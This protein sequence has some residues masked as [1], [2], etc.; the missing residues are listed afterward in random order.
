MPLEF[1]ADKPA[2]V[3][4]IKDAS[5]AVAGKAL[6]PIMQAVK[7]IADGPNYVTVTGSDYDSFIVAEVL[8]DDKSNLSVIGAGT[9]CCAGAQL[10]KIVESLPP[11]QVVH[12]KVD[13]KGMLAITAGG[14]KFEIATM[15]AEDYPNLPS[16]D[17][18]VIEVS[19]VVFAQAIDSVVDYADSSKAGVLSGCNLVFDGGHVKSAATDTNIVAAY[20][21]AAGVT[22]KATALIP[23]VMAKK[24]ASIINGQ[25]E[26]D[27]QICVSDSFVFIKSTYRK[28]ITRLIAGVYPQYEQV[29][30]KRENMPILVN[31]NKALL[32]DSINRVKLM[33]DTTCNFIELETTGNVIKLSAKSG[34]TGAG[35]DLI[36]WDN[37]E[38][39]DIKI[40]LNSSLLLSCLSGISSDNVWLR[41]DAPLKPVLITEDRV[42]SE[43]QYLLMPVNTAKR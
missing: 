13:K 12:F 1:I 14:A 27:L 16:F 26:G 42:D 18:G 33:A 11:D 2:L 23:A 4:A 36:A 37:K 43:A 31:I 30:P 19:D 9:I 29:M 32:V 8:A 20:D 24:F 6:V 21:V 34:L 39:G 25:P 38:G 41:L 28:L 35:E 5:K 3:R 7:I 10:A 17:G 22:G 15:P 40:G